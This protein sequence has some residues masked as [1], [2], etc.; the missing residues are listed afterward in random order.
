MA[1]APSPAPFQTYSKPQGLFFSTVVRDRLENQSVLIF[2][3]VVLPGDRVWPRCCTCT[4]W[5]AWLYTAPASK[6]QSC[7]FLLLVSLGSGSFSLT[8]LG[9]VEEL[10]GARLLVL[11][12]ASLPSSLEV[13][14]PV[15][16]QLS[17]C[18]G[19]LCFS[20][21]FCHLCLRK[22]PGDKAMGSNCCRREV[23]PPDRPR[24]LA[25]T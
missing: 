12:A 7:L 25:G 11:S 16:K 1:F 3:S 15:S 23:G 10:S 20:L 17:S 13:K 24:D 6:E 9:L 22:C 8:H 5:A 21:S 19:C 14:T 18:L 4:R 2:S